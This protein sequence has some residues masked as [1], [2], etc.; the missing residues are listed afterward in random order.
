MMATTYV[1][2]KHHKQIFIVSCSQIATKQQVLRLASCEKLFTSATAI[3]FCTGPSQ[4]ATKHVHMHVTSQLQACYEHTHSRPSSG[5]PSCWRWNVRLLLV[6]LAHNGSSLLRP[7]HHC[8]DP[9]LRRSSTI[10]T[11]ALELLLH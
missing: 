7:D 8:Y 9:R 1:I 4:S 6:D 11:I 2:V 3:R 5:I 10:C